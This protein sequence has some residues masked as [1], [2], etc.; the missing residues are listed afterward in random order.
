MAEVAIL[1]IAGVEEWDWD[2]CCVCG[3]TEVT[4]RRWAMMAPD[5]AGRMGW[6]AAP[7]C[8]TDLVTSTNLLSVDHLTPLGPTQ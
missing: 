7:E 1:R 2:L 8:V 6:C 4:E 5:L 3:D